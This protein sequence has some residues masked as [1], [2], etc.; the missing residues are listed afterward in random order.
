VRNG[1]LQSVYK[2]DSAVLPVVPRCECIRCSKS[3]HPIQNPSYKSHTPPTRD[4][5]DR[6]GQTYN[7]NV[8]EN[9]TE[10]SVSM[11]RWIF[12][13]EQNVFLYVKVL[14]KHL[15]GGNEYKHLK[16]SYSMAYSLAD[17]WTNSIS[18]T[19]QER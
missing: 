7:Y 19:K 16:L 12:L 14:L 5:I 15:T 18:N 4:N 10:L 13:N 8:Y 17:I 6:E 9:E 3:T 1:E 2:S 11:Q